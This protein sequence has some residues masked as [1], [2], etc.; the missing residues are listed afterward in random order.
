M[1][2]GYM[3]LESEQQ[4]SPRPGLLKEV[5]ATKVYHIWIV[6]TIYILCELP[7]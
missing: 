6:I 1:A 2:A 5:R 4:N 3:D 7:D